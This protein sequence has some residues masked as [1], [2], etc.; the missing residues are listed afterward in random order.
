MFPSKPIASRKQMGRSAVTNGKVLHSNAA[1]IDG[2]GHN[3]RRFRDLVNAF[4]ADLG[5][6]TEVDRA[7]IKNAAT[8]ALKME[9]LQADLVAGKEVDADQLIRLAGTS[10]RALAAVTATAVERKPGS[11]TLPEYLAR[12][13]AERDALLET[14]EDDGES[15]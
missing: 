5:E 13:A 10:K 14:D 3:A 15:I 7:L 9:L 12:K 11:E 2:R 4:S 1:Q 8:L 6:L